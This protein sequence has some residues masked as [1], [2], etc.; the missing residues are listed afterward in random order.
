MGREIE[1]D[2][3]DEGEESD[4]DDYRDASF[5]DT[6]L[7]EGLSIHPLR[8]CKNRIYPMFLAILRSYTESNYRQ[9]C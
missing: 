7:L 1:S 8:L 4:D 2:E 5:K 9:T 3:S 6:S